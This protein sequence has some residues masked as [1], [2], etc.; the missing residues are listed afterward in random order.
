MKPRW[1]GATLLAAA[2]ALALLPMTANATP[3]P[4]P[5]PLSP[6]AGATVDQPVF[7]WQPVDGAA[8]YEIEVALDDQF[9]T[10]TDP[11]DEVA[12]RVVKGTTYVPTYSYTAK[13]HYWHV[14]AVSADGAKGTW[15]APREF[16]RRWTNDDEAAGVEQV[17]P[18]STGGERAVAGR[19]RHAASGP[20]GARMGPRAGCRFLPGGV[21]TV[22]G[23]AQMLCT[24][25]H[26][27]LIPPFRGSYAPRSPLGSCS[28]LSPLR[29]WVDG[30]AWSE[31]TP[32]TLAIEGS[33]VRTGDLR[34]RA[35]P[36]QGR[37]TRGAGALPCRRNVRPV[38]NRRLSP[39]R[40]FRSQPTPIRR[41]S[42]SWSH[43]RWKPTSPTTRGC[44]PS[45][46]TPPTIREP[47]SSA[48]GP[49]NVGSRASRC[50]PM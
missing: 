12:P 10:V 17:S 38:P 23:S 4:A 13:T 7:S 20:G 2:F 39:S 41:C 48:C 3:L 22:D 33:G 47:A 26:A 42:T 36:E 9:V 25:P 43:C 11:G 50:P 19:R 29:A 44:A 18:A 31:P 14:R 30:S 16:T 5:A 37:F 34:L 45:T 49:T 15:S 27:A 21:G 35:L 46:R 1:T 32:G 28:L 40:G 6:T 24:T 8:S